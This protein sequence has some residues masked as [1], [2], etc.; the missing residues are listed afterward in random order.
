MS[1]SPSSSTLTLLFSCCIGC[2]I[3][4]V[5]MYVHSL[6][7]RIQNLHSS[8]QG[9]QSGRRLQEGKQKSIRYSVLQEKL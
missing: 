3:T 9:C 4:A 7:Q 8:D 5:C 1:T 2:R 6:R